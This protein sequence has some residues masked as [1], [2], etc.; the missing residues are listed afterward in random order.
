MD[1]AQSFRREV[2]AW[3]LAADKF[4]YAQSTLRESEIN[5][6]AHPCNVAT[7][8]QERDAVGRRGMGTVTGGL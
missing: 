8:H 7:G 2:V 5:G 1:R 4:G 3:C 6:A